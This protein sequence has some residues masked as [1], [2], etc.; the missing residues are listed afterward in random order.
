M[1]G[2]VP[3]APPPKKKKGAARHIFKTLASVISVIFSEPIYTRIWT[4]GTAN[5]LSF[6]FALRLS[7]QTQQTFLL[8]FFLFQKE[9]QMIK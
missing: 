4:N 2:R 7:T 9:N 5:F 8:Y 6:S 1:L 3:P